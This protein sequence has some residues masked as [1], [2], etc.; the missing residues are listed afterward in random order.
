[1]DAALVCAGELARFLVGQVLQ[2][3]LRNLWLIPS[4]GQQEGLGDC[5]GAVVG[6]VPTQLPSTQLSTVVQ[7]SSSSQEAVLSVVVQP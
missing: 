1:M 6:V 4:H 7:A 2:D 5:V 3:L